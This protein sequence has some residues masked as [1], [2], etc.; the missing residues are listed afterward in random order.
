M[1]FILVALIVWVLL[2]A[3]SSIFNSY[4]VRKREETIDA[5]KQFRWEL[6]QKGVVVQIEFSPNVLE[7]GFDEDAAL[8]ASPTLRSPE[9][10]DISIG[11]LRVLVAVAIAL[12]GPFCLR[13][14]CRDYLQLR[15]L[16]KAQ[17][18]LLQIGESLLQS[19]VENDS[20]EIAL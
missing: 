7:M 16:R 5:M 9:M 2:G 17:A 13:S 6:W 11:T 8:K 20:S 14:V 15:K 4:I 3:M 12:L 10:A 1:N 18:D 19:K